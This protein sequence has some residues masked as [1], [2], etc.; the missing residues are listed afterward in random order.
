MTDRIDLILGSALG[1]ELTREEASLLAQ[2]WA[3]QGN[4]APYLHLLNT[5]GQSEN[6]VSYL[7]TRWPDL[8]AFAKDFPANGYV[9][10]KE[11]ID[12]AFA[13]RRTG[14]QDMFDDAMSRIRAAHDSLTAHG[15]THGVFFANEAA[16]YAMANDRGPALKF[17]AAAVDGGQIFTARM[18]DEM[19]WFIDFEGE[20]EFKAI[21]QRMIEH[22]NLER[23]KLGLDSVSI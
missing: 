10:Y 22:L 11:M 8:D 2:Q 18:T 6:L 21:R 12:I 19:P 17:L 16:Y 20:P 14:R 13:C 15:L 3:A 7:E 1:A 9:G 23:N 5:T 4:I